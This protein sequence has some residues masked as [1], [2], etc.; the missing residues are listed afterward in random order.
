MK[1]L[2]ASFVPGGALGLAIAETT[3]THYQLNKTTSR[4]GNSL[5]DIK[6]SNRA[7]WDDWLHVFFYVL[8]VYVLC[9]FIFSSNPPSTAFL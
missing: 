3:K 5:L 7:S 1:L 4:T 2:I 8:C 9:S 6:W